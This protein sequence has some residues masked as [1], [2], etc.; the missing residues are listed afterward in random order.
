MNINTNSN[1]GLNRIYLWCLIWAV[2]IQIMYSFIWV[3]R[4]DLVTTI[5]V[6]RVVIYLLS[7]LNYIVYG[8]FNKEK[9]PYFI[10]NTLSNIKGKD[11]RAAINTMI[12]MIWVFIFS[13][14]SYFIYE[15]TSN[16]TLSVLYIVATYQQI[17]VAI[18]DKYFGRKRYPILRNLHYLS[19][20][21]LLIVNAQI[22]GFAKLILKDYSLYLNIFISNLVVVLYATVFA[23]E[24]TYG[25]ILSYGSKVMSKSFE[26]FLVFG[27]TY[28]LL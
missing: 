25:S 11:K 8:F 3:I 14:Q 2:A 27:A 24:T 13:F 9:F 23:Y 19:S 6:R 28:L 7:I 1:S 16:I 18:A 20:L 17:I 15:D 22:W 5:S 26:L 4:Y 21:I 12:V 10:C